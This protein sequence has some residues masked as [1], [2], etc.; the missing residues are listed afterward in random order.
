MSGFNVFIYEDVNGLPAG[1]P[2]MPGT[3]V[4]DLG[5]IGLANIIEHDE[6][7]NGNSDFTIDLIS[8]NGG[9][10]AVLEPGTYWLVANPQ[11]TTPSNSVDSRWHWSVG[12]AFPE[13]APVFIDPDLVFPDAMALDWTPAEASVSFAVPAFAWLLLDS[14]VL[15]I[16]DNVIEGLSISPNPTNGIVNFNLPGGDQLENISVYDISGRQIMSNNNVNTVDLTNYSNGI[17]IAKITAAN[18]TT[19]SSRIVK[20]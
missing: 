12:T 3:A 8:A 5:G 6:P 19:Q 10:P 20:R 17:Y 14:S 15:S 11:V 18:G 1:D 7:G 4:V 16:A 13:V 9:T 2:T